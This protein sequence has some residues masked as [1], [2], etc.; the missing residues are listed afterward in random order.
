MVGKIKLLSSLLAFISGTLMYVCY[1]IWNST[2]RKAQDIQ[3][4]NLLT[5]TEDCNDS[6]SMQH[7]GTR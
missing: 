3:N 1:G 2:E 4:E 5:S 7:E 6:D